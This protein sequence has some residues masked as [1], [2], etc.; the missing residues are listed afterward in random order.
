[1]KFG[2]QLQRQQVQEWAR[3]YLNYKSLKQSIKQAAVSSTASASE[4]AENPGVLAFYYALDRELEKVDGFFLRRWQELDRRSSLLADKWAMYTALSEEEREEQR[5]H[6]AVEREDRGLGGVGDPLQ[7]FTVAVSHLH[8]YL[9]R[10]HAYASLNTLG[11]GKI[12]KKFDKRLHRTTRSI[13]LTSKVNPLPFASGTIL[14]QL[15][16]RVKSL[17]TE[18]LTEEKRVR[19]APEGSRQS[20]P[21]L[22]SSSSVT[23]TNGDHISPTKESDGLDGRDLSLL[24][25]AIDQNDPKEL[26]ALWSQFSP[27]L[28]LRGRTKTLETILSDLNFDAVA[29]AH[30]DVYERSILHKLVLNGGSF[31][32]P[33]TSSPNSSTKL[34]KDGIGTPIYPTSPTHLDATSSNPSAF[35][36]S[37]DS[38]NEEEK[39]AERKA[40]ELV[41]FL[42][43]RLPT[44]PP[45]LFGRHPLHYA[46]LAGHASIAK[47]LCQVAR[48]QRFLSPDPDQP[49]DVG[50]RLWCDREG[51]TP[52]FY[53]ILRGHASVVHVLLTDGDST[54]L[55][56]FMEEEPASSGTTGNSPIPTIHDLSPLGLACH[57]GHDATVRVLLQAGADPGL[58]DEDG[59]TPLHLA[60]RASSLPCV[61]ALLSHHQ[62]T[63][64][65]K[66]LN[67]PQLNLNAQE[68]DHG[69]SPLFLAAIQGDLEV[70]RALVDSGAD[71]RLRD[72][73]D[74][75]AHEY[76]SYQGHM[77]SA[78]L[79]RSGRVGLEDRDEQQRQE[80]EEEV[81]IKE[82]PR[83][84]LP[85]SPS[86]PMTTSPPRRRRTLVE[87]RAYGHKY[88]KDTCM[89]VLTLGSVDGRRWK[90]DPVRLRG[91]EMSL[92]AV[93]PGTA[94]SL[95]VSVD[96]EVA[97]PV[98]I[99][100]RDGTLL[101]LP[102]KE[103]GAD[104]FLIQASHRAKELP[105]YLDLYPRY[106]L[107]TPSSPG[108]SQ[109]LGRAT[110]LVRVSQSRL[111]EEEEE[112]TEEEPEDD[113]FGRRR[114]RVPILSTEGMQVIGRITL[115][116]L[117]IRPFVH[118][119]IG[120]GARHTY[121]KS[122]STKII[123]HRGSGANRRVEGGNSALQVGENTVL[124][125]VT[126]ASLGAEYV[127][128]DVQLTKDGVPVIYHDWCVTETGLDIPI[129]GLSSRQFL[130]LRPSTS[131]AAEH[132][133]PFP[134]F[135]PH[136][137]SS[138]FALRHPHA[139][140]ESDQEGGEGGTGEYGLASTTSPS[141]LRDPPPS[142][143][144]KATRSVSMTAIRRANQMAREREAKLLGAKPLPPG[145]MKG[146]SYGTIQAPFATLE[147]T[148]KKVPETTGFNI[149]VKYP[150]PDEA[151]AA[152]LRPRNMGGFV[153][154][155]LQVVYDQAGERNILFSS[156]NPDVC[157]I[158]ALKQPNYPVFFLTDA[159]TV[160]VAD[161]RCQS[162]SAAVQFA[163]DAHLMG[164]VSH[165]PPLLEAPR[166][167]RAIRE[168]GLLVFTY[169]AL[170]N[171][172][173]NAQL[174]RESGVDAVI[175]DS[176]LAVR[177]GL[178]S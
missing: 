45:D 46:A 19:G 44:L 41:T 106:G 74:W 135:G 166:L 52:L 107:G 163:R 38:S 2:K 120:V 18:I 72:Y 153:D 81:K 60:V 150:M 154:K 25:S 104:A 127:E 83:A 167:V 61:M 49:F 168:S 64:T 77:E 95:G 178:H 14:A 89:V 82:G 125:F 128:F 5:S 176:V 43:R 157:R 134:R 15:D 51:Y 161:I 59:S 137:L 62:H 53:A 3:Y 174:Q 140:G 30:A 117:V 48:E 141:L 99:E 66:A 138:D 50:N 80:Q 33:T 47:A 65:S 159:G 55:D 20:T 170:N 57:L 92:T 29:E 63:L 151:E 21:P 69:W 67:A 98:S 118:R 143:G 11:F 86:P 1:M 23:P 162:L 10:L 96:E 111:I 148:L 177:N 94:L 97:G 24:R 131:P 13:V 116:V 103:D 76:A 123:G 84:D 87:E 36:P 91:T 139:H 172:V 34:L 175:V 37:G 39:E 160:P 88:L 71:L 109:A 144:G 105:I 102:L 28:T 124:S 126:A 31:A 108:S 42:A 54:S 26:K 146:N 40:V 133:D 35:S 122:M 56:T 90:E 136:A 27:K 4:E 142:E 169:G 93:M 113:I 16:D 70:V 165:C 155:I 132:R 9:D 68:K 171:D 79:L 17:R 130:R 78:S 85:K 156:F 145:K 75:T 73:S 121:W 158:L 6:W 100:G 8:R 119:S 58:A 149:E 129:S 152:E 12:L 114:M 110:A 32:L 7:E 147:E 164:V 22:P 101:D 115:E 112:E 173:R